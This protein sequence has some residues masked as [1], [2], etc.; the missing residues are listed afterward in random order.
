M[1]RDQ[2]AI[3][4]LKQALLTYPN[5][6]GARLALL[7]AYVELGRDQ[8]ARVEAAEVMRIHPGLIVVHGPF[9]DEA[10]NKRVERDFRKAGLK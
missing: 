3:P 10:L 6:M 2:E 8:D 4:L 7:M 5:H 1:G 9:K